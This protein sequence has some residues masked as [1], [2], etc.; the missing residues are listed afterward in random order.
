MS[1]S[2]Y[3]AQATLNSIFGKTSNFGALGAAP[4]VHVGLSSTTPA[5]DGTNVA[6]PS[7]GSYARVA[8]ASGD[9]NSA[10]LADPSNLDNA[11]QIAFPQ[12][13]ADWR[14]GANLTHVV[15]Y[16]AATGGN[17]LGAF[18]LTTAKPVLNGDQ[19]VIDPGDAN[20]T[21]D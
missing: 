8:T 14:A 15:F 9:W 20:I 17:F 16:D 11:N 2:N 12:A 21:L 3:T 6:E 19:F 5:E 10:T 1:F 18:A 13:T 4:T 7:G